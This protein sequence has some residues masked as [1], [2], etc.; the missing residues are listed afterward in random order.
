MHYMHCYNGDYRGADLVRMKW[1]HIKI[2]MFLCLELPNSSNIMLLCL[3]ILQ[4]S[5]LRIFE[6]LMG[7]LVALQEEHTL[8]VMHR[9][10]PYYQTL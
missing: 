2:C 6:L 8:G 10:Y 9:S 7:E 1:F 5:E 4:N 3:V